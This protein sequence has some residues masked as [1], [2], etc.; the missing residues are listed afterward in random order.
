MYNSNYILHYYFR[1][2]N[3]MLTISPMKTRINTYSSSD[4]HCI[5][6]GQIEK[7]CSIQFS[8]FS[9]TFGKLKWQTSSSVKSKKSF[10][11]FGIGA[12]NGSVDKIFVNASSPNFTVGMYM[13][14]ACNAT[15]LSASGDGSCTKAEFGTVPPR[16]LLPLPYRTSPTIGRFAT[17]DN[18]DRTTCLAPLLVRTA[19]RCSCVAAAILRGRVSKWRTLI[20]Q[21]RS[22]VFKCCFGCRSKS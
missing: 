3:T 2:E 6:S 21:I 15:D 8:S 20:L 10:H 9:S 18:M 14:R 22:F 4:C 19:T 7:F 17:C 1:E 12:T 11:V 5:Y 13:H 16:P